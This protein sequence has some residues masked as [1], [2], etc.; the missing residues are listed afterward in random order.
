MS[1]F[2]C[3][4]Q[5]TWRGRHTATRAALAGMEITTPLELFLVMGGDV[6]QFDDEADSGAR[7]DLRSHGYK[8]EMVAIRFYG[9][10][11]ERGL[12]HEHWPEDDQWPA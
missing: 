12:R 11:E 9:P 6:D 1:V 8:P 5:L 7:A 10:L 3:E 2:G 4:V